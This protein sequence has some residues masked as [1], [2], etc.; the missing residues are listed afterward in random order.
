MDQIV[1]DIG[2]RLRQAREQRGLT[3]RDIATITKI[4]LTALTAIEHSD[5]ARLPGGVFRTAYVRAFAAEVGLNADELAREY[6]ARFE[7]ESPAGCLYG[8][9]PIGRIAFVTQRLPAVLVTIVGIVIY[10]SLILERGS[11][12]QEASD[13]RGMLDAVEAELPDNTPQTDDSDGTEEVAFANAAVADIRAPSLRL[14][15]RTKGPCWVATVADGERVV[16]RL[17]QPGERTLVEARV[18]I[19]LRVGDAGTVASSIDGATARPLGRKG[20]AVTVRVT[21]DNLGSLSAEP[22]SPDSRKGAATRIGQRPGGNLEANGQ[23]AV[24]A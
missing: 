8:T 7:T 2:S 14:E 4:S 11:V 16:H 17:M 23:R 10:G 21:N 5:F 6:R 15:I 19:T 3:L 9:K 24:A 18:A 1:T 12:P 22:A 20:E 13:G